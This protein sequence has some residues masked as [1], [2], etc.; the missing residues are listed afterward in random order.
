M[1]CA[2][3]SVYKWITPLEEASCVKTDPETG[4][5]EDAIGTLAYGRGVG[6]EEEDLRRCWH[7]RLFWFLTVRLLVKFDDENPT[8]RSIVD[9]HGM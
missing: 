6:E 9:V 1:L 4:V 2:V 7:G 8:S 5:L 3:G